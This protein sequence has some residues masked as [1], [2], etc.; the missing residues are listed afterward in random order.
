VSWRTVVA[1]ALLIC[2][3]GIELLAVLGLCALRDVYDR[4]HYVGLVGYGALLIAV[5]IVVHS[6]FSLLGDKSLLIGA[7]LVISG[8]VL[9]HT[10][11]RS[12]L[13]RELGD[14]RAAMEDATRDGE[15]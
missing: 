10:T 13:T 14:W 11:I 7:L 2:G 5:S 4:L 12:L 15:S 6:S 3:V 1:T 8:P 9:A